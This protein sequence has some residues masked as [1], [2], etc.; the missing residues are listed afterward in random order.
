MSN[1]PSQA[2]ENAEVLSALMDNESSELELRRLLND[3]PRHPELAHVWNRYN[4]A[5]SVLQKE[6]VFTVSAG[7]T[8][9]ILAALAEETPY[10]AGKRSSGRVAP[11]WLPV[12][13]RL[14]IAASVALAVFVGLQSALDYG[15]SADLVAGTTD[16]APA[17]APEQSP[18]L[19][20]V[21][22]E[23]TFDADAQQRLNDYI[24][25]VSI[26]FRENEPS[27]PAFNILQDSQL[28][29]QVNQIEN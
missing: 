26:Q 23:T 15:G 22:A 21:A 6:E 25:G 5:R 11:S 7:G 13:G 10:S 20:E 18:H 8:Q 2:S 16:M 28:I 3:I 4:L 9:R 27:N 29:R 14:A 17:V 12:A 1:Q 24:R 19:T